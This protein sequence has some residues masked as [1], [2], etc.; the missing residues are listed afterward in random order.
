MP[1]GTREDSQTV[2]TSKPAGARSDASRGCTAISR[3]IFQEFGKGGKKLK[4]I[5]WKAL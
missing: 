2:L 4:C 3:A 5:G 1:Q